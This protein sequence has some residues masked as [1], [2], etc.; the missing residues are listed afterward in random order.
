MNKGHTT[1]SC[2][3]HIYVPVFLSEN[4]RNFE[5]AL[6]ILSIAK[7]RVNFKLRRQFVNCSARLLH[8]LEMEHA[9]QA[10]ITP[11]HLLN[12]YGE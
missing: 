12:I 2:N 5:I 8:N 1:A 7:L 11:L 6:R 3:V 4:L 9:E 10:A